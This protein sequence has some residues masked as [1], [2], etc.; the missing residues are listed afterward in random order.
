MAEDG[1]SD[2]AVKKLQKSFKHM[3]NM[4]EYI[5]LA[6][7]RIDSLNKGFI[8]Y[9]KIDSDPVT[10]VH[11]DELVNTTKQVVN[12][13]IKSFQVDFDIGQLPKL[14]VCP[15]EVCFI[16]SILHQRRCFGGGQSRA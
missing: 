1:A 16:L 13:R 11:L 8:T 4:L 5:E 6:G 7:R 15:S 10:N 2:A 9:S 12:S 14:T 3:R